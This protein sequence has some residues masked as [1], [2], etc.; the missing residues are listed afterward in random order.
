M[1]PSL[2]STVRQSY[3]EAG[4]L[5]PGRVLD[6]H[7]LYGDGGYPAMGLVSIF[8]ECRLFYPNPMVI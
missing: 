5:R 7:S 2:R 1:L 3:A 8:S 4:G 6:H